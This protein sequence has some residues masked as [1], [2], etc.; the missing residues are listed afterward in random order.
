MAGIAGI[1]WRRL[2]LRASVWAGSPRLHANLK[3]HADYRSARSPRMKLRAVIFDFGN[4]I[5]R[6]PTDQQIG[7]AAALCGITADEFLDAFWRKRREYDRGVDARKYWK[8]FA[9]YIGRDF[10]EP[11]LN[12]MMRREVDFWTTFDMRVL[13]WTKDLR[14]AGLKTSI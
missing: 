10:D 6:P 5:C 9:D 3:V 11:L 2:W 1:T 14:R 12:E 4:V 8:E 7:E 13:N